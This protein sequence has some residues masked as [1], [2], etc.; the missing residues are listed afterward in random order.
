MFIFVFLNM[1]NI[2]NNQH[3]LK[4]NIF[5][6]WEKTW[7]SFDVDAAADIERLFIL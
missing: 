1:L 7:Y 2:T 4:A 5:K 6:N 3:I